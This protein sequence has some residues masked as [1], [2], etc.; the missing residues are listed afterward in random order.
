MKDY[1]TIR[2]SAAALLALLTASFSLTACNN[3]SVEVV[4]RETYAGTHV[5]TATD[6]GKPFLSGGRTDYTLVY[7]ADASATVIRAKN[8]FVYLFKKATGYSLSAVTDEGLTHSPNGKYISLGETN[9]LRTSGLA[10]DKKA[11]GTDGGRIVTKDDTVYVVGGA[12]KG[13]LY[14]VY[15]YMGL[16]F[17]FE[18]YYIDC[19]EIDEGVTEMT[20]QNYDVT[21]IPDIPVRGN[22]TGLFNLDYEDYDENNFAVRM[23]MGTNLWETIMPIHEEI[24]NPD[25]RKKQVHNS[26]YYIPD[27]QY[28][29]KTDY[30]SNNKKQL[31]YTAHGNE[32]AL[33][34][35]IDIC[36]EKVQYSLQLYTPDLY[37]QYKVATLT[38]EDTPQSCT[39]GTCSAMKTEYGTNAAA[40]IRF[41]NRVAE[42][43][44]AWMDEAENAAYK[45][46]DFHL[47]FFAYESFSQPPA[48]YDEKLKAYR[49]IDDSVKFRPN[50][51]LYY[52]PLRDLEFQVD[53]YDEINVNGKKQ[54]DAWASISDYTYYWFYATIFENYNYI[55]DSF[56]FFTGDMYAYIANR[57]AE[58]LFTQQQH[59]Q[60][61]TST[62]WHNLKF[63]LDAKLSW[64]CSLDEAAL[65]DAWFNAMYKEA[66]PIMK[67]LYYKQRAWARSEYEKADLIQV[68]SC[69]NKVAQSTFWPYLTLQSWL[70]EYDGAIAA[71]KKYETSN[72]A[73]YES[74]C[75][76]IYAEWIFPAFATLQLW[77]NSGVITEADRAA[78]IEKFKMVLD[79]VDPNGTMQYTDFSATYR[80]F[81]NGL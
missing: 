80:G 70:K 29:H 60:S 27:T 57:D 11:L 15:T 20:L 33:Q 74:L 69:Y 47:I 76:H 4:E 34:E 16:A 77:D 39:C 46:E 49:P 26:F 72:P 32:Q 62:A 73:L 43:V 30:F 52:A 9:L 36:A 23:K 48:K 28:A 58:Y 44:E 25:S 2:K 38:I 14:A 54:M 75:N 63:Y 35:M 10:I 17:D 3:E 5:Y 41:V 24:G 37:P 51:G 6:T 71:V 21:D 1:K 59:D 12:D 22:G 55:Y 66:A 53:L 56:N 7:P 45:R 40:A 65:T 8:E 78:L 50:V 19:Y 61:G 42:K 68:N 67:N 31:C 18:Q 64:D 81:I 79:R 13:T